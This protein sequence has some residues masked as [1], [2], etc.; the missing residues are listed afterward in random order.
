MNGFL[1]INN[2]CSLGVRTSMHINTKFLRGIRDGYYVFA[3]DSSSFVRLYYLL[4][5]CNSYYYTQF[6]VR[7]LSDLFD[8]DAARVDFVR[9][10]LPNSDLDKLLCCNLTDVQRKKLLLFVA[11]ANTGVKYNLDI[12]EFY[13]VSFHHDCY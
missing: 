2:P 12:I 9:S 3:S 13:L 5:D 10:C 4:S 11:E 7:L 8:D 6:V 1:C